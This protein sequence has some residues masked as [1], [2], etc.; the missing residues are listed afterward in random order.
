MR[1]NYPKSR[2]D[3]EVTMVEQMEYIQWREFTKFRTVENNLWYLLTS[4]WLG[5]SSNI[6]GDLRCP[7]R[8]PWK[9]MPDQFIYWLHYACFH[10]QLY[11]RWLFDF[12][13]INIESMRDHC[14]ENNN[15]EWVTKM[16]SCADLL[17]YLGAAMWTIWFYSCYTFFHCRELQ[18]FLMN[19]LLIMVIVST[20]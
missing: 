16:L 2:M 14:P 8:R 18:P 20:Y 1:L 3:L 10:E 9:P 12:L 13:N 4:N 7:S 6:F 19:Y 17:L 11:K 5:G 15:W